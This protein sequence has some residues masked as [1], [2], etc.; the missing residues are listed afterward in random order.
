M[1]QRS[2]FHASRFKWIYGVSQIYE[3]FCKTRQTSGLAVI[4]ARETHFISSNRFERLF[5]YFVFYLV[6]VAYIFKN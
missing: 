2:D 5:V 1:I 6:C 4:C 3:D